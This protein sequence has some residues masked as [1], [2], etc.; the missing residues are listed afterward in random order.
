MLQGTGLILEPHVSGKIVGALIF[1]L[2]TFLLSAVIMGPILVLF[3]IRKSIR[4]LEVREG[5]F[6]AWAERVERKEPT[7]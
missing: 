4:F 1:A 2:A 6:A 7:L 5:S 3:D